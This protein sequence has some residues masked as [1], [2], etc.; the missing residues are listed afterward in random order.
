MSTWSDAMSSGTFRLERRKAPLRCPW[1]GDRTDVYIYIYIQKSDG[2][3]L[4][5]LV[6]FWGF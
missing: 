1:W 4:M 2:L 3:I 6:L 5:N